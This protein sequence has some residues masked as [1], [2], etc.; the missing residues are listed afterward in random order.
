MREHLK[1]NVADKN[2]RPEVHA[3][4]RDL[5]LSGSTPVWQAGWIALD[6]NYSATPHYLDHAQEQYIHNRSGWS[7]GQSPPGVPCSTPAEARA[8]SLSL[9]MHHKL[10]GIRE[11]LKDVL[12][13]LGTQWAQDREQLGGRGMQCAPWMWQEARGMLINKV[14]VDDGD[15]LICTR[16]C[17]RKNE[18]PMARPS[19]TTRTLEQAFTVDCFDDIVLSVPLLA[20]AASGCSSGFPKKVF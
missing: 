9:V 12:S 17:P 5:H 14:F 3:N 4:L 1:E 7:V 13:R 15:A 6:D 20:P 10:Q 18:R 16:V 2:L 11:F 8:Q 19:V